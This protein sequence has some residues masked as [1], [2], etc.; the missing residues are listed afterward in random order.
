MIDSYQ[1]VATRMRRGVVSGSTSEGRLLVR[2]QWSDRVFTCD[3]L[4]LIAGPRLEYRVGT[5][6]LLL[7]SDDDEEI[8]YVLGALGAATS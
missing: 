6:V 1:E 5:E 8:G 3:A 4:R 2:E 7:V